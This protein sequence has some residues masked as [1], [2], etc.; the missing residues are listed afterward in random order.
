MLVDGNNTT[1]TVDSNVSDEGSID[2]NGNMLVTITVH[3]ADSVGVLVNGQDA[4]MS[5][6]GSIYVTDYGIG[7]ALTK[8]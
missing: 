2:L 4:E 6:R 8:R 1:S 7:R 5:N 3:D